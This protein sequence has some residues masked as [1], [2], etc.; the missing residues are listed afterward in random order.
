[1]LNG[2]AALL[3]RVTV[4]DNLASS[5]GAIFS[6]AVGVATLRNSTVSG[7]VASGNYGGIYAAGTGSILSIHN[8]TIADN[9]RTNTAGVGGTAWRWS[10][11]RKRP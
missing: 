9:W 2:G 5:G 7:N 6:Q 3:E 10:A 8:S 1:M 4:M 11:A